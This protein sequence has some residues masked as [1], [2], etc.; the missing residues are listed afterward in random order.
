MNSGT[1]AVMMGIRTTRAFTGRTRIAKCE[2]AYHGSYDWA[3]VGQTTPPEMWSA[4]R[5]VSTRYVKGTPQSV[6]DEVLVL[7]FNRTE[8]SASILAEHGE[9][10]AAI[11][12]DPMPMRA[13]LAPARR[14]F[15]EMLRV[16]CDR[17]GTLLVF[18]EVISFRL[19]FHG[20]Q[21]EI[22]VKPDITTLGKIIG[23]GFPVG[24][25]AGRAD[26][27]DVFN[28]TAGSPVFSHGGTFNANPVTMAA[29]MAALELLTPDV[30]K[31]LAARG[32]QVRQ[33]IDAVFARKGYAGCATGAGSLTKVH[34]HAGPIDDYR[35]AYP[36]GASKEA[37]GRLLPALM[38]R[39]VMATPVGLVSLSTAM[40]EGDIAFLIEALEGAIGEAIG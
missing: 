6:L 19:G 25:I 5:P 10:L 38:R 17:T 14:E 15:L 35:S 37:L 13:G 16:F 8:Q 22:G 28:P 39:G 21:G 1:E 32:E 33:A 23:G 9:D 26:V 4:N 2:G 3:E 18:D 36:Q 24:A 34:F 11:V 29:G 30:F 20:A 40:T 12:V 7:P 31:T 27:M